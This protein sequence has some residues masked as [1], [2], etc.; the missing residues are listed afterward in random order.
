[1]R[2]HPYVTRLVVVIEDHNTVVVY[3]HGGGAVC[4]GRDTEF[5]IDRVFSVYTGYRALDSTATAA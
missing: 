1:M 2:D 4:A 3:P 5:G